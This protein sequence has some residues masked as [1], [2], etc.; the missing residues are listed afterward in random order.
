MWIILVVVI[1][2]IVGLGVLA[3]RRRRYVSSPADQRD[4]ARAALD[5]NNR[6]SGPGGMSPPG[7]A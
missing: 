5:A 3:V 4:A 2:A 7:S 1:A 6:A